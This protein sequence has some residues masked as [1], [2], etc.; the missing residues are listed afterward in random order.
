[1][2]K[3]MIGTTVLSCLLSAP[4]FAVWETSEIMTDP[5]TDEASRYMVQDVS[6]Q[7]AF[8]LKCWNDKGNTW[9]LIITTSDAHPAGVKLDPISIQVRVGDVTE[10]I[11]AKRHNHRGT[12]LIGTTIPATIY[13]ALKTQNES[14]GKMAFMYN[15]KVYKIDMRGFDRSMARMVE[16]C[17]K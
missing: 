5:M 2:N 10:A 11:Y 15:N 12:I 8:G 3:M 14:N 17:E 9:N 13:A 16:T 1:M 6:S 7:V 4:A